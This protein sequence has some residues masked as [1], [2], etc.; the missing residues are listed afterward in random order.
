[1]SKE[2]LAKLVGCSTRAVEYWESGKRNITLEFADKVFNAL[3]VTLT[4]GY[5]IKSQ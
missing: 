5:V 3:E 1:M 4:I 2:S